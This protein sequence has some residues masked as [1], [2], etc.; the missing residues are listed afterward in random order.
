MSDE[1]R[2]RKRD[3]RRGDALVGRRL[4][5]AD[6]AVGAQSQSWLAVIDSSRSGNEGEVVRTGHRAA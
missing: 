4:A 6:E 5:I 2:E 3:R 1:V